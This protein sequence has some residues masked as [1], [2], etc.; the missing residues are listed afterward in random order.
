[1]RYSAVSNPP[2]RTHPAGILIANVGSPAAPTAGAVRA[3]L[4]RFLGDPRVVELPRLRWWLLRNLFVLPF[5]PRRSAELYRRIWSPEGSPLLVTT[6]RQAAALEEE[7]ARRHGER[8][9][10]A[11]GM[12][13]G[14]PFIAEGLRELRERGC[15]RVLILPL[16]P[17]YS[18]TTTA[19]VF[20]AVSRELVTWRRVPELRFVAGYHDHRAYIDA[21]AASVEQTWREGGTPSRLLLS[22][23]GLPVR[24]VD[25][26]DPY[27]AQ[28]RRTAGLLTNALDIEHD[29]VVTGFQSRFGREPW[30]EPATDALLRTWGSEGLEGLDVLCPGFAADCLE[31]LEEIALSGRDTFEL[32][33][34][35]KFRYLPAL[36]DRPD[37]IAALADVADR[38]L[39]GWVE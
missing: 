31:T 20:D 9:P 13:Y 1:M 7:L 2:A 26:G 30:L 36:N 32:A 21:L 17:Q 22:F 34:G 5:R 12:A 4:R 6:G 29:R 39:A 14:T 28:C 33:G 35:R 24:Y 19:S 8:L 15:V 38:H 23:H 10:V 25:A 18:G 11:L 3:F 27:P 37:H 16:F